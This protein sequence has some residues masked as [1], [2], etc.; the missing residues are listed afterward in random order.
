MT[1]PQ[2]RA[3]S[4]IRTEQLLKDLLD[5]KKTPRVPVDIRDRAKQCLRHYPCEVHVDQLAVLAPD[6]LWTEEAQR[7]IAAAER[8]AA[9]LA[10]PINEKWLSTIARQS[11]DG[12][13]INAQLAVWY[14]E[15]CHEWLAMHTGAG[16]AIKLAGGREQLLSLLKGLGIEVAK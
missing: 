11:A 4:I 1:Q 13:V 12:W 8:E 2:E 9:E 14:G 3:R 5:P 16:T 6:M 7:R 10:E 15:H